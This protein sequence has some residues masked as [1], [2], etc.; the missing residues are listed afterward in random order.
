MTDQNVQLWGIAGDVQKIIGLHA[1]AKLLK[2]FV[3]RR[4]KDGR[5]YTRVSVPHSALITPQHPISRVVGYDNALRLA[6]EY[7]GETL[8]LPRN[9]HILL[10]ARNKL[11][12][13]LSF[14][15]EPGEIAELLTMTSRTVRNIQETYL[16]E[17]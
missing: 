8:E 1:T 3:S 10:E 16:G 12:A 14:L 6:E 15:Y 4:R 11:I 5:R 17:D 9:H 13:E 7:G 2:A